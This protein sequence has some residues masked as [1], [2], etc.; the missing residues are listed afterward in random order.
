[1]TTTTSTA[2][3][4]SDPQNWYALAQEALADR[5]G[6]DPTV[7]LSAKD[8]A[9]RLAKDG[10][11]ELPAEK[12]VPVWR[13][14]LNQY[15]NY[16][17]L[18]L[19]AAAVL[20]LVI[21]QYTTAIV[22]I[23]IT[24][25]NALAG[26]RQE[27][28]AESAM[29]ALK[30]MMKQTARVRRDGTESTIPAEEVVVGDV[31]LLA[32]GDNVPADGRLIA[33]SSLQIDESALTGESTPASKD[34][35]TLSQSN[36]GLGDQSDMA[37]SNTPVTHGSGVMMVTATAGDT[38]VGKI[39][40]MLAAT[41]PEKT[42]LMKQLD[43]LT[44]WIAGAAGLT[45]IVMF[46]LGLSRNQSKTVL[47]TTAVALAIAAIPEAMPTVLQVILSAGSTRLA[48]H[49]AVVKDLG[50]VETLGA[51]SAINSDKTGTLTMNQMTAVE[52][53][54]PTDRYTIS[55]IGYGL[56][57]G[58]KHAAGKT[59]TIDDAILPFIMANDA[60][61]VDGKVVGDPTEGALLILGHKAGLDV[62]QTQSESPSVATLPFDPIYKMMAT[63]H[64]TKDETGKAVVRCYVKGAAPAVTERAPTA[65]SNGATVQWDE[66]LRRRADDNIER[67]EK[68]GLRVMGAAV[69]DLDATAFDPTGNLLDHVRDLQVTSLVGMIDPPRDESK[70]AVAAAQAAHVRVRMV[71]GDDVV[72]GAAIVEKLGIP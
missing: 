67:M 36:V 30:S 68:T 41:P 29:N 71:T 5:L 26:L 10:P 61:L 43:V 53:V 1:M 44:L 64:E 70:A 65:L 14:F 63:F 52:V 56:E 42:P 17:Q 51:T 72:T 57:G 3:V 15:R 19:V 58:V 16:M 18:I 66:D 9:A 31:V 27:G 37:F 60:K 20:S 46:A 23:L 4:T 69:R 7:G 24:V 33:A 12:L 48:K 55:G 13:Q 62:S 38:Q 2:G 32:A 49:N 50:S 22:V 47:F 54:D 6:V 59:N 39:A 35:A 8:A 25:L 45:M 11:N 34:P 21:A 40:G 28:K